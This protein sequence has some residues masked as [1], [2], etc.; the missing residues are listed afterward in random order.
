MSDPRLTVP[1]I[2]FTWIRLGRNIA[3]PE[4]AAFPPKSNFQLKGFRGFYDVDIFFPIISAASGTD[5]QLSVRRTDKG[6]GGREREKGGK[7]DRIVYNQ[8]PAGEAD[9]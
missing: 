9:D 8:N 4:T 5:P 2:E 7:R 3:S 1:I 6:K